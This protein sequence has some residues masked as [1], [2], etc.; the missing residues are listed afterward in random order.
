MIACPH[1][2]SVGVGFDLA[3]RDASCLVCHRRLGIEDSSWEMVVCPWANECSFSCD[4]NSIALP[5]GAEMSTIGIYK[6]NKSPEI[7]LGLPQ[8]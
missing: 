5:P 6:C 3:V 1:A 4:D 8:V 7:Q 2:V